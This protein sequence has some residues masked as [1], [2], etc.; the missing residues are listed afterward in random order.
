MVYRQD[1]RSLDE[2]IVVG[3]F[4]PRKEKLGTIEDNMTGS[5]DQYS[6]FSTSINR[7]K[8]VSYGKYQYTIYLEPHQEIDTAATLKV[9]HGT[10]SDGVEFAVPGIITPRKKDAVPKSVIV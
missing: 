5:H 10:P 8:S 6:C 2:I 9:S 1:N 3:G 7:L 4:Y